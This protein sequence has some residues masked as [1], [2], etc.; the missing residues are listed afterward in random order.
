MLDRRQVVSALLNQRDDLVVISGLGSPTYDVNAAGDHERNFCLW[1]AMGGAAMIGLGVAL[2]KPETPVLVVTG[3]GEMLMGMGSYSTIALQNPPNLTI[4]V[5]NNRLFGETGGQ[6]THTAQVTNL[7]H[8]AKACGV[9]HIL[10][11]DSM[12]AVVELSA[13][14]HD[15]TKGLTVADIK[16]SQDTPPRVMSSRAGAVLVDRTRRA[17]GLPTA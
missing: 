14:I 9:P 8:V 2:A 7:A 6:A 11:I 4:A 13:K 12:E 15:V 16:V 10:E 3:D 5:L 1:G 17:L